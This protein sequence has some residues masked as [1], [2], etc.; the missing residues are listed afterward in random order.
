MGFLEDVNEADSSGAD[1]DMDV[2]NDQCGRDIGDEP[3]DD[4][5]NHCRRRCRESVDKA[6]SHPG[7]GSNITIARIHSRRATVCLLTY[8]DFA[9]TYTANGELLIQ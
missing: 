5:V 1:R 8:G 3:H 6:H 7:E 9:C 4:T 2:A